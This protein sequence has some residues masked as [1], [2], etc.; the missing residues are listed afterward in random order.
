MILVTIG[1]YCLFL[2]KKI[3]Q[4]QD[5]IIQFEYPLFSLKQIE[6]CARELKLSQAEKEKA[7]K[8]FQDVLQETKAKYKK[9][10]KIKL[11]EEPTLITAINNFSYTTAKNRRLEEEYN[12]LREANYKVK[13]GESIQKLLTEH[14]EK[15]GPLSYSSI[16]AEIKA[17]LLEDLSDKW[18]IYE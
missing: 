1:G 11:G 5:T 7:V 8:A 18:N 9:D 10:S 3:H 13:L 15:F 16:N 6:W 2:L 17:T 4:N 14:Q 12:F